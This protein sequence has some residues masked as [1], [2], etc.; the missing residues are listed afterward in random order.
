MLMETLFTDGQ[1]DQ[2][3]E[4]AIAILSEIGI[5]LHRDDLLRLLASKGYAAVGTSVRIEPQVTRD[6][7]ERGPS[8]SKPKAAAT[9]G[10]GKGGGAGGKGEGA[11]GAGGTGGASAGGKGKAGSSD[12]GI[13]AVV[14]AGRPARPIATR[15][16]GYAHTYEM[17]D[18][19]LIPIDDAGNRRMGEYAAKVAAIWPNFKPSCPGRPTEV[20]PEAQFLRRNVNSAVCCEGYV[21]HE[22]NSVRTSDHHF[23]LCEAL[24]KPVKGLPIFVATPLR[25]AGVSLDIAY[26]HR[27]HIDDVYVMSMPSLGANT[28]LNLVAAYAQTLAENLGGAILFEELTDVR[29]YYGAGLLPFDFRDLSMPFG[30]PEKMLLE[31]ANHE[32]SVRLNG[33]IPSYPDGTDIHT[34]AVRCGVQACAEKASLATLGAFLGAGF[35]PCV[36]TLAMDESFSP[37]QLLLDL[38]ILGHA[39]K[40]ATGLPNDAYVGDLVAEVREGLSKGYLMSDRTLDNMGRYSWNPRF[41]SRKT[42]GAF[43]SR[44]FKSEVEK[45]ADMAS[46]LMSGPAVWRCEAGLERELERIYAS[47]LASLR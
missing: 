13:A 37:V 39:E 8:R 28:P 11:A 18:G 1:I 22:I 26:R 29:T 14:G 43:T 27:D 38:E 45:A 35:M 44:P 19:T 25:M 5:T 31:W 15:T 47:A 7:L 9:A 33:G 20:H 40:I 34:N 10:E 17:M 2:I 23:A 16:N 21:P 6:K 41:F 36:G 12:K 30:T 46:D 32:V 24:G 42:M 4:G 3:R